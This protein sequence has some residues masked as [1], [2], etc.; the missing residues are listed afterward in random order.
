MERAY[1][2]IKRGKF[3]LII[4]IFLTLFYGIYTAQRALAQ[5]GK[6]EIGLNSPTTFPVDI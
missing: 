1:K 3:Y 2:M 5:Y 6:G 4:I